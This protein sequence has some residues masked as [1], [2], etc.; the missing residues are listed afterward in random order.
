MNK[1]IR[2]DEPMTYVT[3]E[4][5][6]LD[7]GGWHF[8]DPASGQD[9]RRM[10]TAA[11][12]C[13][14]ILG[15]ST[16]TMS[17][18]PQAA[19]LRRM[20]SRPMATGSTLLDRGRPGSSRSIATRRFPAGSRCP[21]KVRPPPPVLPSASDPQLAEKKLARCIV[22]DVYRGMEGVE[23]GSIR[24]LRILEQVARPWS[25]RRLAG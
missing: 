8:L 25:A 16:K 4:V 6:V 9:G 14:A 20:L 10:A 5:K 15:R 3:P 18:R 13:S 7:E 2:T 12:R 17:G 19:W 21:L 11:A 1:P 22:T 24:Y 23:R